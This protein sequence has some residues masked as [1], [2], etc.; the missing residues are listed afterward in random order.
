M[1]KQPAWPVF[2]AD[3]YIARYR[4]GIFISNILIHFNYYTL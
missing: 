2:P 3:F 1:Q 4:Y